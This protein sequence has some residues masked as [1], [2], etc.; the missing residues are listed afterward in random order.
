MYIQNLRQFYHMG[1]LYIEGRLVI[2]TVLEADLIRRTVA[3][4]RLRMM[5]ITQRDGS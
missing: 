3:S 4:V 2:Y 5:N 1:V